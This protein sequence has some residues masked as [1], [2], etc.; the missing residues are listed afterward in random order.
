V[1]DKWGIRI[2]NLVCVRL[3]KEHEG[4]RSFL[5]FQAL[6]RVPIQVELLDRTLLGGDE[7]AWLNSYHRTVKT[8]LAPYL[9][10]AE[11]KWLETYSKEL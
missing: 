5:D 3:S 6:T 7:I 1:R 4:S 8:E 10:Q 11:R 2:E 9:D